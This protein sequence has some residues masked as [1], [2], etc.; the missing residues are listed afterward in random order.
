MS[1]RP[2][3]VPK[4]ARPTSLS[5]SVEDRAALSWIQ[6]ARE[7][8]RS[9]R[10]TLNDILVDGLWLLAEK[11]GKTRQEILAMLPPPAPIEA[12]QGNVREMPKKPNRKRPT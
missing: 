4:G 12:V 9:D 10:K 11:E 2:P 1:P 5:L 3:H 8:R 7:N 6:L